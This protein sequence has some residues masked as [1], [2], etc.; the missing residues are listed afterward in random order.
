MY[1]SFLTLAKL[2]KVLKYRKGLMMSF[3]ILNKLGLIIKFPGFGD[4]FVDVELLAL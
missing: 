4:V 1:F 2:L 3:D